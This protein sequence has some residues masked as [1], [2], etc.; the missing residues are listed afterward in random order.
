MRKVLASILLLMLVLIAAWP[1]PA[2]AATELNRALEGAKTYLLNLEKTK[3]SLSS[4]SYV[5]LAVSGAPLNAAG[6]ES[7]LATLDGKETTT[8]ALLILTLLAAGQDPYHYRGANPVAELAAAQLDSGKFADH[9]EEGGEKLVNAHL[10]AVL[11]LRAAGT[12]PNRPEAARQWLLRHQHADGAFHWDA[13]ATAPDVDTTGMAMMTLAALGETPESPAVQKAVAYL[14]QAQLPDGGFASWGAENAE[15]C[16]AVILG[17]VALGLDPRGPDFTRPGG[18]PVSALLRFQLPDGAFEHIKGGGADE[19]AT[20]QALLALAALRQPQVLRSWLQGASASVPA[21]TS[22]PA[23]FQ[24]RFRP[25]QN[26]YFSVRGS[27]TERHRFDPEAAPFTY[28]GRLFVPVRYLA[29]ALGVPEAGI[30]FE[31]GG[32]VILVKG[33][34]RLTL[35]LGQPLLLVNGQPRSLD[36]A[37]LLRNGRSF[38]PAR[39]VAEALGYRV[40]WDAARGEVLITAGQAEL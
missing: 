25:G 35:T 9:L 13:L 36:V 16:S 30:R 27:Q 37:P 7:A 34:T 8:R 23:L 11:A 18:D 33:Q 15:S 26:E 1:V 40:T 38:L 10:W 4:W 20:Q 12:T 14:R 31:A 24:V 19:M 5:A 28:Q 2:R 6:V 29:L 22:H 32:K 39:Y 17:L 21:G 3:G